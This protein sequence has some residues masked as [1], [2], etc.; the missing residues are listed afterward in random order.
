[1]SSTNLGLSSCQTISPGG[2]GSISFS[3]LHLAGLVSSSCIVFAQSQMGD[4]SGVFPAKSSSS[5]DVP[6][7]LL[8]LVPDVRRNDGMQS[9][10]WWWFCLLVFFDWKR[11]HLH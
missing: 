1:M 3:V 5:L 11:S 7:R 2:R 4:G 8:V 10:L 9:Q 6:I